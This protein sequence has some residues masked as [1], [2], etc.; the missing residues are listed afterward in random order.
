MLEEWKMELPKLVISVHGGLQNFKMP[1]KLK[2]TFSQGL[3]KASETTGAWIITEGINSGKAHVIC[4]S[5]F[6]LSFP[7]SLPC[8]SLKIHTRCQHTQEAASD[9]SARA[10]HF[11]LLI[12]APV[13]KGGAF[14]FVS[15]IRVSLLQL[16]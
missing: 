3:V 11:C 13:A 15:H 7:S 1:S 10:S 2:E 9:I 5:I 4:L 16:T 8:P 6:F 12:S 14:I